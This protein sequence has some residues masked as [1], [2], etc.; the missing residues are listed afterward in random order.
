MGWI[1]FVLNLFRTPLS[2]KEQKR[3]RLIMV[4]KLF[5]M[6]SFRR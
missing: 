4:R 2:E 1:K 5:L 3:R 6:V